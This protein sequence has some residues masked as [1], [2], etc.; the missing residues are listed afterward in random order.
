MGIH[1]PSVEATKYVI[2]KLSPFFKGDP[3]RVESVVNIYSNMQMLP[4]YKVL[5]D[6]RIVAVAA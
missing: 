6:M 5:G 2:N 1:I 3:F 4:S